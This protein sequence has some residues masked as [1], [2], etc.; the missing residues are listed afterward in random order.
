MK[1]NFPG[2]LTAAV[3]GI[4]AVF[5]LVYL[6]F[7]NLIPLSG[8]EITREDGVIIPRVIIPQYPDFQFFEDGISMDGL[9]GEENMSA[10]IPLNYGEEIVAILNVDFD[11]LVETQIVAF[12]NLLERSS[13]IYLTYIDFDFRTMSYIR[14][15]TEASYAFIPGTIN[16]YTMDL[17]GD[18]SICILIS[19]LNNLGE[20]TL[21]IFR[22]D[23]PPAAGTFTQIAALVI[24][25][26]IIVREVERSQAYRMGISPGQSFNISAFGRDPETENILDQ[27]E[28]TF[29]FNRESNFYVPINR[30][31]I[32]GAQV[33]QR[34]V[35]E[36]LGNIRAFENFLSG[37]W[38]YVSPEGEIEY[39][40]Y[41]YFDLI[42]REIIFSDIETQQVFRWLNSSVT[43]YGLYI[44][45]QNISIST[46]RRA[47]DIE[48]ESLESV[49]I[50]VL[51]DMRPQIWGNTIW[52]GSYRKAASPEYQAQG[53]SSGIDPFLDAPY[54]SP[55]GRI[56]FF[57]DGR[58]EIHSDDGSN[59]GRYTFF[60]LND[61]NFLELRFPDSRETFAVTGEYPG[62][63][64][65]SRVRIG[66]AGVERLANLPVLL[67]PASD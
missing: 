53:R 57:P 45:S 17:L 47:I 7:P 9:T 62:N 58:V 63:L 35:R 30:T 16:L 1:K 48:L 52:D 21:T 40:Q 20:H 3:F 37:L 26:T 10:R 41:V 25:G 38:H 22:K 2:I 44:S 49:R 67:T 43:R 33:E 6:L 4:T 18:R 39:N 61:A 29:A 24:D 13:P 36:L 14:T 65:L 23:L 27:I 8:T 46:L 51:E 50:R 11:G 31:R 32:P 28:T 56:R 59:I 5:I 19:G 60:T 64:S 55:I 42:S 66:A 12:R 54:D 34:Q 15:W